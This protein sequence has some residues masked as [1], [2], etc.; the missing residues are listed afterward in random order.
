MDMNKACGNCE[1]WAAYDDKKITG[2][3]HYNAPTA[4]VAKASD[5]F[6]VHWP[7]TRT[8]DFCSKHGT[9]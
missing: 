9:K 8:E 7:L 2:H 1:W 4:K 6:N 3:C 5:T